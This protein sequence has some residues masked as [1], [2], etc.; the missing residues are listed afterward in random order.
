MKSYLE[1]LLN[2]WGRKLFKA[3]V[4]KVKHGKKTCKAYLDYIE[5]LI[6]KAYIE[7]NNQQD[8]RN[9]QDLMWYLWC[10]AKSPVFGKDKA[11]TFERYFLSDEE[12]KKE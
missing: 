11:A 5:E 6:N 10:G 9:A 1:R 8:D 4:R 2:Y 7:R 3:D 12:R